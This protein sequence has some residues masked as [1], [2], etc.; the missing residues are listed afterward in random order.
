MS[1]RGGL[2]PSEVA[3]L[4]RVSRM[5]KTYEE[6]ARRQTAI[7]TRLVAENL[8]MR[9]ALEV[10]ASRP[11]TLD[12]AEVAAEALSTTDALRS[13]SEPEPTESTEP[14]DTGGTE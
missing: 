1:R 8:A 13:G 12:A 14:Q 10:I 2:T 5:Q 3:T 9:S 7:I 4:N 11:L 6:Q